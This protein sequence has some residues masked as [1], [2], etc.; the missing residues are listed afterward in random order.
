VDA[1]RDGAHGYLAD[2]ISYV[3][4]SP[5]QP[6]VL[7]HPSLYL[8]LDRTLPYLTSKR[9][10]SRWQSTVKNLLETVTE[11]AWLPPDMFRVAYDSYSVACLHIVHWSCEIA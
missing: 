1:R 6:K 8:Q 5:D 9:K 3:Q 11:S 4:P 7:M 2:R 10:A